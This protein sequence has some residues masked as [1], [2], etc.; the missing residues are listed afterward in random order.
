MKHIIV[1][2]DPGKRAAIACIGLDGR[3]IHA[4]SGLFVGLGW[5]VSQINEVGTPVII[6]SDKKSPNE[7]TVK[8]ASIFN[9]VLFASGY[10]ISVKRKQ[11]MARPYELGNVH[12]RDALSAALSAYNSYQNKMKQAEVF[13]A[14]NGIAD[15][16][17]IK[18]MVIKRYSMREAATEDMTAAR[19][20][21]M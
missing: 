20:K 14:R 19:F 10:D 12:E 5:L 8:L 15:T 3:L 2:I 16:D 13:A 7:T 6:A 11:E 4:S 18:A 1:G 9:A 21:R 17:R